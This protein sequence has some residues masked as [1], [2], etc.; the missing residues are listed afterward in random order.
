[1][2]QSWEAPLMMVVCHRHLYRNN[3]FMVKHTLYITYTVVYERLSF[4]RVVISRK[5]RQGFVSL[6]SLEWIQFRPPLYYTV[7]HTHTI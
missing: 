6:V 2:Y 7:Y 4:L 3:L 1:M 5:M